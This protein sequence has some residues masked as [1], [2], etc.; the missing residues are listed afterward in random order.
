MIDLPTYNTENWSIQS[1]GEGSSN[2]TFDDN[3]IITLGLYNYHTYNQQPLNIQKQYNVYFYQNG[4]SGNVA[5]GICSDLESNNRYGKLSSSANGG[6][7]GINKATLSYEDGKWY[8]QFNTAVKLVL[9]STQSTMYLNLTTTLSS[10][11]PVIKLLAIT[12]EDYTGG[13]AMDKYTVTVEADTEEHPFTTDLFTGT[14]TTNADG[15][16]HIPTD[17]IT[18]YFR[19]ED[20]EDWIIQT[21]IKINTYSTSQMG[22]A[23]DSVGDGHNFGVWNIHG[24]WIDYNDNTESGSTRIPLD[25]ITYGSGSTLRCTIKRDGNTVTWKITDENGN[26][27]TIPLENITQTRNTRFYTRAYGNTPGDIDMMDYT[28]LTKIE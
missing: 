4:N 20:D 13:G 12:E 22:V 17:Y 8:V 14:F 21:T 5:I 19:Y 15:S 27:Q 23:T 10:Q 11:N 3:G 26:T 18:D 1:R 28:R 24:R 25:Q 2:T 6:I 7:T 16:L 9:T